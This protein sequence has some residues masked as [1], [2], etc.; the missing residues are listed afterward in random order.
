[1]LERFRIDGQVAIVTGASKGLGRATAE[2]DLSHLAQS[3]QESTQ[4][5]LDEVLAD[6]TVQILAYIP[7]TPI[8][9]AV[10]TCV[11]KGPDGAL[12]ILTDEDRGRI[13]RLTPEGQTSQ[14]R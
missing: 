13:L 4:A 3:C 9:D 2:S 10:P 6:G 14:Q 1:M 5:T 7:N 11:A 12:Y 8:S